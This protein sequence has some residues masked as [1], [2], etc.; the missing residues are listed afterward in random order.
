MVEW[1][2]PRLKRWLPWLIMWA[3]VGA[4]IYHVIDYTEY[5][6]Q[7]LIKILYV[8]NGGL[9]IWGALIA[10]FVVMTY[11]AWKQ[12]YTT[13]ELLELFGQMVSPLPLA[14]AFGRVANGVNGEFTTRILGLPWWGAEAALDI[15]LALLIVRV[16]M[17]KRGF[18]YVL[19]YG[20]I[21]LVLSPY[22]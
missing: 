7:D 2:E 1:R 11:I 17:T 20:L 3:F 9:S 15:V 22:R 18:V 4:R 21:R 10:A 16:G 5:Y 6:R 8:W 13:T 19:G 12:K 14:Q